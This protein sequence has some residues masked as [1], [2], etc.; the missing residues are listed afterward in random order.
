[1]D[2][3]D[4]HLQMDLE[5]LLRQAAMRSVEYAVYVLRDVSK[6]QPTWGED[7]FKAKIQVLYDQIGRPEWTQVGGL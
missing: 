1:M 5:A 6:K 3:C 2:G 7:Y 4:L